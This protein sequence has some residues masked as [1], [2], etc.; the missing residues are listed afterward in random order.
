MIQSLAYIGFTSPNAEQWRSFGPEVL[1]LELTDPGP[2]GSLRLRNDDQAWRI[3]MHPGDADG[4]AYLGWA[5]DGPEGLAAT[6]AAVTAAG[7]EVHTGDADL[8]ATRG[9]D[10]V[11]WY[12]DPFGFRHE[13]AH[14]FAT[15]APFAPG[16]PGVSFV[17]GDG[18]LGHAVLIV[19]DMQAATDFYVG[20]LGFEHSDDIDMGLF[21]RFLHCN[22]RH[23]TLAFSAVPGMV[24]MHHLMLEVADPDEV[25]RALDI[26]NERGMQLA[27]TLGRHTND[28]MFSFYVRTPS[29]FEVEYGAGGRLI[30]ATRPWT[31]EEHDAMSYWGHKPPADPLFP[32]ILAPF[33]PASAQEVHP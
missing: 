13:L 9:A 24:G 14:G 3:A 27:M 25:G 30:D 10:E 19:P 23:H 1:G 11:A 12:L 22:P 7:F 5:V 18:G 6:A 17:T 28:E 15:G 20:V 31:P 8:A 29:G 21:V 2:D 33:E 4:L 16:R 26:V 32:G